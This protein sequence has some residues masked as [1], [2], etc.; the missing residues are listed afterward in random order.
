LYTVT[1]D[2]H[3][4]ATVAAFWRQA[5]DYRVAYATE[6]EVAIEPGG[7]TPAPALLFIAVPDAKRVKNRLHFDLAPDD[8][9]AEVARLVALGARPVDIGQGEVSWV[10]LADPEGNEFCVLTPREQ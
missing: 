5:L 6:D 1:I 9:A 2:A 8:Q 7:D 3:D 4:P 10:V